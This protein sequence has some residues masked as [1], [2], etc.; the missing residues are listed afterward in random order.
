MP[1]ANSK[2]D[3]MSTRRCRRRL[4]LFLLLHNNG[5]ISEARTSGNLQ[6]RATGA[7]YLAGRVI[8]ELIDRTTNK[9]N[10]E[11]LIGS[12]R[13]EPGAVDTLS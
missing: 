2:F 1:S 11:I 3:K 4:L 13:R 8:G 7:G 9:R 6:G 12:P 10:G 5:A